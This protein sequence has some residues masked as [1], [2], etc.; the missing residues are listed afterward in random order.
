MHKSKKLILLLS[1][2]LLVASLF[3]G[4]LEAKTAFMPEPELIPDPNLNKTFY[5]N[6]QKITLTDTITQN[7]RTYIQLREFCQKSGISINWV[8]RL[9][10]PLPTQGGSAPDGIHLGIPTFIYTRNVGYYGEKPLPHVDITE[11]YEKYKD[12][13]NL[14]YAFNDQGFV[15]QT[16]GEKEVLEL[17]YKPFEERWYIPVDEFREKVQPYFV[18]LCIKPLK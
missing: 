15:I 5:L 3:V 4:S 8:K 2:L 14:K 13:K 12:G 16:N 18:D 17:S 7:N 10:A 6:G 1:S 11:I 9:Y